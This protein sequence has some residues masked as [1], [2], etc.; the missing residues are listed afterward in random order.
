MAHVADVVV[1]RTTGHVQVERVVCAQE[2]G[3]VVN[4]TGAKMQMEGCITMG[5]GYALT[6]GVRFR[7]RGA[8]FDVR[9]RTIEG[10]ASKDSERTKNLLRRMGIRFAYEVSDGAWAPWRD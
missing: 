1:D 10:P 8:L 7:V 2:M 3:V 9:A 5:L 4:P 6:E